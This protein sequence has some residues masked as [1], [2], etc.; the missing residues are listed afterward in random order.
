LEL[1]LSYAI[2]RIGY[3]H[4]CMPTIQ[5]ILVLCVNETLSTTNR[6]VISTR[7]GDTIVKK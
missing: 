4:L 6:G 2:S 5:L 1:I 3:G 7:G